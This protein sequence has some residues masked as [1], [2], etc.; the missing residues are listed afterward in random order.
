[1]YTRAAASTVMSDTQGLIAYAPEVADNQTLFSLRRLGLQVPIST[2]PLPHLPHLTPLP[3]PSPPPQFTTTTTTP[4]TSPAAPPATTTTTIS[5]TTIITF[6]TLLRC[7][8]FVL[9]ATKIS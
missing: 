1:M 3:P 8:L 2:P 6:G 4:L 5:T 9:G 7:W